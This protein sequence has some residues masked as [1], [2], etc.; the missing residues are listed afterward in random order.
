MDCKVNQFL[1]PIAEKPPVVMAY[2]ESIP[3]V[4]DA[5]QDLWGTVD[6][7]AVD[8]DMVSSSRG[9]EDTPHE[10]PPQLPMKKE[11]QSEGSCGIEALSLM[12]KGYKA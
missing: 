12:L 7:W 4:I 8:E 3:E 5:L 6:L 10:A 11:V 9:H 2:N 1:K